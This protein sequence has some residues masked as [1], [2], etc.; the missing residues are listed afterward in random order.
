MA[1]ARKR[2]SPP[3]APEGE[4]PRATRLQDAGGSPVKTLKNRG[5]VKREP[6]VR[7][8]KQGKDGL[9]ERDKKEKKEVRF[10]KRG[11]NKGN[12]KRGSGSDHT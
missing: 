8:R 3:L 11:E 2:K 10:S 5:C 6:G 1:R 4:Y 7:A 12:R 9:A